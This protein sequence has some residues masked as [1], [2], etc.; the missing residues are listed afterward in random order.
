MIS[1]SRPYHIKKQE[2]SS[3]LIKR[4]TP[5]PSLNTHRISPHISHLLYPKSLLLIVPLVPLIL[6]PTPPS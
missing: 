5:K 4:L 1:P 2:L 3:P 6:F